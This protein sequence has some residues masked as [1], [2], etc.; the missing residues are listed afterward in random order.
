MSD[1]LLSI[2]ARSALQSSLLPWMDQ[3]RR[4]LPWRETRDPWGV[5][6]A[7][8]MLQ[9]TQVARVTVKWVEFLNAF[10][11]TGAAVAAGS[12]QISRAW[13]GLGYNR[14]AV[15]LFRCAETIEEHFDGV[16]PTTL[17]DLLSLPGVGPY[18]A[19]A[20]LAFAFTAD[21]GVVDTNVA[22]ILAR[23]VAGRP[24]AISE[25]QSLADALV[26]GGFGW[27]WNQGMLDL[28]ATICTKKRPLCDECPIR[29]KCAWQ[30][31]DDNSTDPAIGS[32][33]VPGQQ[34]K[35]AGS[36]RE[37]R[38]RLV[39]ALRKSS[40]AFV[41]LPAVMGWPED[42]ERVLRVAETV[43][44]DGLAAWNGDRSLLVLG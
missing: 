27:S 2:R 29:S 38:G 1:E 12:A 13:E 4:D 8:C 18:T 35:F 25:A 21:V 32:A 37:G 16:F 10:P 7:E 41:E 33:G 22:R 39:S 14:R 44:R 17:A 19:R 24:L 26:P 30:A 15:Q 42:Q 23:A 36:D 3:H 40:V 34:S 5:L 9:Q 43:V 6:V 31:G 20:V 28:G 11:T